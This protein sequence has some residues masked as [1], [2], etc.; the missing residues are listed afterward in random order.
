MIE[1]YY[2]KD[3]Q[4][5]GKSTHETRDQAMAAMANFKTENPSDAYHCFI[6]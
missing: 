3:G 6:A 1:V 2:Y 4:Y 5:W